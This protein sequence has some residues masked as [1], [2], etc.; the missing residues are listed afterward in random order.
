MNIEG[1]L[2]TVQQEMDQVLIHLE[3]EFSTISA[4]RASTNMV[5]HLMVESYGGVKMP[6]KGI[7]SI[8]IPE[9]SQIVIQPWDKNQLANIEKA[10]KTSGHD[11]NPQNDGSIIRIIIPKPT[12]EKRKDLIKMVHEKAEEA[13]VGLRTARQ[14]LHT[15]I[16]NAKE[17]S[18][19]TEDD[20]Y[21]YNDRLDKVT[22]AEKKK[23][24]ELVAHK[25]K[26]LM[27]I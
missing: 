11:F 18:D 27:T 26:E 3:Q 2:T 15:E 6:M 23:V 16:K 1:G 25:E 22:N 7:A 13:N 5:D 14:K 20:F 17:T 19:I 10:L 9:P 21:D 24:D 8:T 4:G 12:E